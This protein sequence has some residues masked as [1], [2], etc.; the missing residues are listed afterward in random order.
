M[1]DQMLI[2]LDKLNLKATMTQA[3]VKYLQKLL[4]KLM[5]QV[6]VLKTVLL[7]LHT[8]KQAVITLVQ[9]SQAQILN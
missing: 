5:M 8:R 1:L 6:M 3:L 7:K 9:D 4:Q 2:I